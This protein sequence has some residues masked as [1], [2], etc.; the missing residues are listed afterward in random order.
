MSRKDDAR[1]VL[2]ESINACPCNW[3]AWE[4]L[5][6]ICPDLNTVESMVNIPN[7]WMKSFFIA[8][9][10]KE[11]QMN[12]ESI[13]EYEAL[14]NFFPNSAHIVSQTAVAYYYAQGIMN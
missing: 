14:N 2:I 4:D 8:Y 7:H 6:H 10:Y 1:I 5:V 9:L 13:Q 11:L 12:Y 3:S